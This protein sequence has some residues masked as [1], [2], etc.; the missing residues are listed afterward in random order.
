MF[1]VVTYII[2]A[3][4]SH[5]TKEKKRAEKNNVLSPK[6]SAIV[7]NLLTPS[8]KVIFLLMENSTISS[9]CERVVTIEMIT[10]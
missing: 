7:E 8:I 1:N 5:Q 4:P 2:A 10:Y 3:I 6:D 9:P